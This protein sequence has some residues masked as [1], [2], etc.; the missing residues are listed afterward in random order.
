MRRDAAFLILSAACALSGAGPNR[1]NACDRISAA[2]RAKQQSANQP[3]QVDGIAARIEGDIITESEID[4]LS[5]FQRLVEGKSGSRNDVILEL[6]DQWIVKNEAQNAHF[7]RPSAEDVNDALAS[8][9][10]QFGSDAA[11]QQK[12][13]QAGLTPAAV[14]REL[15]LQLYLNRYLDYKF[16]A[17][18]QVTEN[19]IQDYYRGEFARE[20]RAKGQTLPP[21][22]DVHADIHRLLTERMIT[23]RATKWLDDT[24]SRLRLEIMPKAGGS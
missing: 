21:L 5:A 13:A 17:A 18:A 1:V 19:Q 2:T 6:S 24:R 16:R 9:T 3:L 8:L 23:D 22:D 14:R 11:F 15:E 7:A 4:E 10:K 20:V 12:I